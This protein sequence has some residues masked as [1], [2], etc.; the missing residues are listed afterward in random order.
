M[1]SE[2]PVA[3]QPQFCLL[4]APE[5]QCGGEPVAI[6]GTRQRIVLASLLL[7]V[8]RV[9][10]TERLIT[11]VW[12]DEP[13]L[14][15][16]TQIQISIS[17]LRSLL[18]G[19]GL[20]DAIATHESGYLIRVAADAVDVNRFRSLVARGRQARQQRD[21]SGAVGALRQALDLWRGDALAGLRSRL[22]QAVALRLEEERRAVVEECIDLELDRGHHHEVI[23]ELRGLVAAHP[24]QEKLYRQLMLAL[25]RDGRQAEALA[26]Y[27]EARRVL[28]DQHGLDPSEELR[29]LERA[30]LD[31]DPD[32]ARRPVVEPERSVPRQL[33][34]PA[35][36]LVG[37]TEVQEKLRQV[38]T[39]S[40]NPP[41]AVVSGPAGVGKSALA[42]TVGYD[43]ADHFPDG[44]LFAHLRRADGQPVPSEQ[45]LDYFL[46]ALG[47]APATL[48][49]DQKAL[50]GLYRSRLA[51]RRLLILLDD[52]GSAGQVEP[53]LPAGAGVAVI[54]TSRGALPG[55]PN[56]NRFDL[57]SLEPEASYLLLSGSVGAD[58]VS[59]EPEASAKVADLCAHLPLALRIAAAKLAARPH[60][61]ITRMVR[62][63][64]DESGRLDELSLD[65]TGVRASIAVSVEALGPPARRLLPLLGTLGAVDFAGWVAGPLLD[66]DVHEGADVLD[67]LVDARLVEV[68]AGAGA[69][70]R[71]RLHDLVGV[72]AR[73]LLATEVT[74]DER[75]AAQRRLLGCWAF[76]SGQAHRREYGGDYTV[77]RS[78]AVHR[79]MPAD[80][81]DELLADPIGWFEAEHTNLVAAVRLAAELDV[82]DLCG[83]VAVTSVTFFEARSHR[84]DWRETHDVALQAAMRHGDRRVEANV[85]CSRAGLALVEQRFEEA[86]ADLT[87][88][89]SWFTHVDDAHGRGLS[90]RGLGSIERLQ[91]RHDLARQRY[92]Q[93]LSDL[94]ASGD[95]VAEA[96]VL[97]NLAEV[98]AESGDPRRAEELLHTALE[99]CTRLRVR[100]VVAQARYRLGQLCLDRGDLSGAQDE[101]DAALATVKMLDD[102]VG[103]AYALLGS[104]KVQVGRGEL[105]VARCTF[106]E[107]LDAMR[108]AGSRLGEGRVLLAIAEVRLRSDEPAAADALIRQA[109]AA[110]AGIGA[111]RWRER[112]RQFRRRLLDEF[113]DGE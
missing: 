72:F 14:T 25:Y 44:H 41:V 42:V 16:R 3:D 28:V 89:L 60:W 24:L 15:A 96:H 29:T 7:D 95:D 76:L 83:D 78:T 68:Q 87:V 32:V 61:Q 59:A 2:V 111:E 37:R 91:G 38:L 1:A 13:P 58:R 92:E 94:R 31:A 48:P 53:L 84:E 101:F 98:D 46:R 108:H 105:T 65:G 62:R 85:R 113:Y 67:D 45:V 64:G 5:I 70:A 110:F 99:I 6:G 86:R 39:S 112:A 50:A 30:I 57:A 88:A 80:I 22:I 34:A 102:P 93:A 97:I 49:R 75:A 47:V 23:G 8:G 55:L 106:D 36:G 73:E 18:A 54:V 40:G 12:D 52:A 74:A 27:R 66:V 81:L 103:R 9:L 51:G 107:A 17:K 104:G 19:L 33:P 90:L 77:P 82:P 43:V 4:G 109:E 26:A 20:P 11:A 69:R 56:A 35:Y 63:L 71:Y 79:S 21:T 100:R 10:P